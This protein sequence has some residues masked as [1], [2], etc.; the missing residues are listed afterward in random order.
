VF[1]SS[2]PFAEWDLISIK[3][4]ILL[5]GTSNI[6]LMLSLTPL[7]GWVKGGGGLQ[8]THK[9]LWVPSDI[10]F[11]S[12]ASGVQGD[13]VGLLFKSEGVLGTICSTKNANYCFKLL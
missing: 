9:K 12:L 6:K 8:G 5:C 4:L 2:L 7:V 10:E 3:R 1:V 13:R 11:V